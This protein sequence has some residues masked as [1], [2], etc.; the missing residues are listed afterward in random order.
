[1]SVF[2]Y[3]SVTYAFVLYCIVSFQASIVACRYLYL[4]LVYDGVLIRYAGRLYSDA[5]IIPRHV[6]DIVKAYDRLHA[7]KC[8]KYCIAE[9]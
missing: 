6:T 3:K 2:T 8:Y 1:M 7:S 9:A 4:Y 5:V